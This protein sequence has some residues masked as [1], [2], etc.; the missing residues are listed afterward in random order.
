MSITV[1]ATGFPTDY[2]NSDGETNVDAIP[3]KPLVP[4]PHTPSKPPNPAPP[5]NRK[6]FVAIEE[7]KK[8]VST[9]KPGGIR[10]FLKRLI[11]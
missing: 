5:A 11:E 6:P 9:G 7:P 1:L 2:F 4:S 3:S 10:G 8:D